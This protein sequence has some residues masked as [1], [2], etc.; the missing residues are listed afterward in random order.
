MVLDAAVNHHKNIFVDQ[1]SSNLAKTLGR[2]R[3]LIGLLEDVQVP[4]QR[5]GNVSKCEAIS[6]DGVVGCFGSYNAAHLIV[7]LIDIE[8]AFEGEEV[9]LCH[10]VGQC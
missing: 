1:A 7:F 2:G 6:E 10:C 4:V 5:A 3:K 9:D 8:Q